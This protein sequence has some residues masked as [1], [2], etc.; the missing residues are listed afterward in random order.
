M[1]KFKKIILV[2]LVFFF[3]FLIYYAN[4]YYR[5]KESANEIYQENGSLTF[6]ALNEDLGFI[7]YPGGKVDEKAYS[8]L[9][10]KLNEEGYKVVIAKFPFK[11]GILD[12]NEAENIIKKNPNIKSWVIVGHSLGGTCASMYVADNNTLVTGIAFLGS[13]TNENLRDLPIKTISILG[14]NDKIVNMENYENTKEMYNTS[15]KFYEIEGGNHA[16]YG[17]YGEQEGDGE[18]TIS[19]EEQIDLSVKYILENFTVKEGSE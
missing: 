7:I 14:T 15:H 12:T 10:K 1:K 8:P 5:A 9:A 2:V 17:V 11:L 16:Y 13:Y 4:D 6:D 18:A 19:N 3:A